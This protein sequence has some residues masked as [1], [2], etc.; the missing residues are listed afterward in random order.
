M[1]P[2]TPLLPA[3]ITTCADVLSQ[4]FQLPA[5]K[6]F[7]FKAITLHEPPKAE[8]IAWSSDKGPKPPRLGCA[9]FYIRGTE[10]IYEVLVNIS[11]RTLCSQALA[12]AGCHGPA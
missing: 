5:G 1:H 7:Q 4:N 2:L 6:K 9:I 3:E 10:Q 11:T 8:L 12:P